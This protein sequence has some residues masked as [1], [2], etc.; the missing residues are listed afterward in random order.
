MNINQFKVI[1]ER[2]T[3]HIQRIKITPTENNQIIYAR[4]IQTSV[5]SKRISD[6][7]IENKIFTKL[8]KTTA[9]TDVHT[10]SNK[11]K[12]IPKETPITMQAESIS[13]Q[14]KH[15]VP[16]T[17]EKRNVSPTYLNKQP[18]IFIPSSSKKIKKFWETHFESSSWTQKIN[19]DLI[20]E[21]FKQ[22]VYYRGESKEYFNIISGNIAKSTKTCYLIKPKSELATMHLLSLP[23]SSAS[24]NKNENSKQSLIFFDLV[25][26]RGL[27]T[28]KSS[29]SMS[30]KCPFLYDLVDAKCGSH[31]IAIT[32]TWLTKNHY[33]AEI[34]K[35]FTN[36]NLS[37]AD[38]LV[39]TA[40]KQTTENDD[41]DD[42]DTLLKKN[43]GCLLLTT[44]DIITKDV[45][46]FSNGNCE[47]LISELPSFH[48]SILL[49]Y[50][51][52]GMNFNPKKFK[53]AFDKIK[54]YLLQNDEKDYPSKVIMTGDFNFP[55]PLVEWIEEN[56]MVFAEYT[57]GS[58]GEK[59]I[60]QDLLTTADD[61]GL[62]QIVTKPTR[63][64][65][66]LDLVFTNEPSL[67]S[68]LSITVIEPVSD[69]N[70]VHF[71]IKPHSM[72]P[73]NPTTPTPPGKI[74]S[75]L[76]NYN[77]K[78]SDHN[79]I[80]E[81]MNKKNWNEIISADVKVE[82]LHRKFLNALLDIAVKAGVQKFNRNGAKAG[83]KPEI[84]KLIAE[85]DRLNNSL[86]QKY[87]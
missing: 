56:N 87:I 75:D 17:P 58:S 78:G 76:S 15:M 43:G 60:L 85:R 3:M 49:L 66:I 34:L 63:K 22:T 4:R 86:N 71:D 6:T 84:T 14:I 30:N 70:I 79:K 47:L 24:T 23:E 77:F 12:I 55:P 2:T 39:A 40:F 37:R 31:I 73:I 64:N 41:D 27:L 35:T 54:Q 25:N 32:E 46:R 29:L 28:K 44:P 8:P 48:M 36:Y 42:D 18:Q 65:N 11:N 45:L 26:I 13:I 38:R 59:V 74:E 69:H 50:R 53:E 21:V 67:F 61:Y 57:E 80:K 83:T 9:E 7:N 81:E 19:K 62:Y 20:F 16:K 10:N 68:S 33:D 5:T 72:H 1:T 82:D 51:P 52:S